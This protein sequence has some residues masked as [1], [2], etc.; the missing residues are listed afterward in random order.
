MSGTEPIALKSNWGQFGDEKFILRKFS[1]FSPSIRIEEAA[2][3][4]GFVVYQF[5][6]GAIFAGVAPQNRKNVNN[7]GGEIATPNFPRYSNTVHQS[8]FSIAF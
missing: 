8:P 6:C 4:G 3:K 7:T 2:S 1:C 5:S